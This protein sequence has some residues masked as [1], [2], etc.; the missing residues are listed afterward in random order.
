M[1]KRGS[2]DQIKFHYKTGSG[3]RTRI[4]AKLPPSARYSTES[5]KSPQGNPRVQ[6]IKAEGHDMQRLFSKLTH[7]VNRYIIDDVSD[8]LT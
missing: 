1:S 2:E 4:S 8:C 5:R 6:M 3:S 7:T